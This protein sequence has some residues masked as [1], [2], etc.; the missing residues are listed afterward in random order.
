MS[1]KVIGLTEFCRRVTAI[2]GETGEAPPEGYVR[3]RAGL[4]VD[5]VKKVGQSWRNPRNADE[6]QRAIEQSIGAMHKHYKVFLIEY[7]MKGDSEVDD[8]TPTHYSDEYVPEE[9]G[10]TIP[11][12]DVSEERSPSSKALA[13]VGMHHLKMITD[14]DRRIT[15][16]TDDNRNLE[17]EKARLEF[18]IELLETGAGIAKWKVAREMFSEGLEKGLPHIPQVAKIVSDYVE[19]LKMEAENK[20]EALGKERKGNAAP[21]GATAEETLDACIKAATDIFAMHPELYTHD[22]ALTLIPIV[23]GFKKAG[24]MP[25]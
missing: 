8:E 23:M 13:V 10:L 7:V 19:V 20:A 9:T 4:K 14:K 17:L 18:Q 6:L 12:L 2:D 11:D 15:E 24:A 21:K 5:K 22:R 1:V 16:L 25:A 3:I